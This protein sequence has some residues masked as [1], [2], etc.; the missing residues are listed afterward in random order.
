MLENIDVDKDY[1]PE[2]TVQ[3]EW[4]CVYG[5]S[6]GCGPEQEVR[7]VPF[8][9]EEQGVS[10]S[11]W[12]QQRVVLKVRVKITAQAGWSLVLNQH[13]GRRKGA[14]LLDIPQSIPLKHLA[15]QTAVIVLLSIHGHEL[16]HKDHGY[17][18]VAIPEAGTT[19]YQYL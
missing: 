8:F 7:V 11:S 9:Q 12:V 18:Y 10:E 5:E 14:L 19:I 2:L 1:L 17:H 13:Q 4:D 6:R 3:L 15:D 16:A